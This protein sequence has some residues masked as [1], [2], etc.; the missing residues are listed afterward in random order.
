MENLN[1]LPSTKPKKPDGGEPGVLDEGRGGIKKLETAQEFLAE[2]GFAF[3]ESAYMGDD[4]VDVPLL[5]QVALPAAP[6]QAEKAVRDIVSFV[7]EREG[8]AGAIRDFANMV[9]EA[10]GIDPFSLPPQ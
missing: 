10:R 8:G 1:S 7:A 2:K 9:L 6:A 5:K 4:L 3:S